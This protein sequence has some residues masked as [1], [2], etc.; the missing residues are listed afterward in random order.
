MTIRKAIAQDID[1]LKSTPSTDL[2]GLAIKLDNAI[3]QI[4]RLP[5]SGEAPIAHATPHAAAPARQR[6]DRG[7]DRPAALESVVAAVH[8]RHRP[9]VDEPRAVRR[10][11]NADAMLVIA[12]S[13]LFRARES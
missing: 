8:D 12:R 3:D 9:A 7:R 13:G 2:T 6:V 10:I 1:K 4:D 11:D 5:L